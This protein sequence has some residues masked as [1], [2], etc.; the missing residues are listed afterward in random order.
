MHIMS[1]DGH[2]I[3]ADLGC[4]HGQVARVGGKPH[5]KGDGFLLAHV[6][7]DRLLQRNV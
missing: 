3:D 1:V 5:A 2:N 6:L 4:K 7:S